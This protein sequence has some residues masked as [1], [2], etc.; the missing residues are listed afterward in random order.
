[1][2][3]QLIGLVGRKGVGKDTAALYLERVHGFK[4]LAFADSLKTVCTALYNVDPSVFH[5]PALKEEPIDGWGVTPRHIMQTVGT[6]MVRAHLGD[7]FWIRRVASELPQEGHVVISDVRFKHEADFIRSRGGLLVRIVSQSQQPG[8]VDLH[9]SE[10]ESDSVEV[11]T[12][13]VNV[14]D[15]KGCMFEQL[16]VAVTLKK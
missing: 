15:H 12:V 9:V 10:T 5:D 3:L 14:F 11:D 13:V 4:R 6:D 1:M 2:P 16:D 8:P 7:D